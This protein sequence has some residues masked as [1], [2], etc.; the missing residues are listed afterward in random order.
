MN[1]IAGVYKL[2]QKAGHGAFGTVYY[3]KNAISGQKVA[4]KIL[5]TRH[6]KRELSGLIRYRE[7]R[8]VNLLQ[9]HHIDRLPDGR[10]FYTMDLADNRASAGYEADTLAARGRIPVE[11]LV[12]VLQAI[13]NSVEELHRQDLL[14]RDIKPENILFVNGVP[15]LGDIGLTSGVEHTSCAGTP[16]Y[17]P[18]EIL[19]GKRLPD[20][21]ADLYALGRTAYSALTGYAPDKYPDIPGDL[22]PEAAKILAFCRIAGKK[23]ATI[24]K[25]RT[26][27]TEK[28]VFHFS[29][30]HLFTGSFI[31]AV[32][33]GVTIF[34]AVPNKDYPHTVTRSMPIAEKSDDKIQPATSLSDSKLKQTLSEIQ[35]QY[36][37]ISGELAAQARLR[38]QSEHNKSISL[39]KS[40][41][42]FE[43]MLKRQQELQNLEQT[44]KLYH[45]GSILQQIE[46]Y[47]QKLSFSSNTY[48][49]QA[50][51]QLFRERNKLAK[52]LQ[53][54]KNF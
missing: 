30:K 14:H 21:S 23:D 25:L 2:L 8:H 37:D 6:E 32:T 4:L 29:K 45:L 47:T 20:K 1:N 31:L 34:L 12:Y 17:L 49:I 15:V 48:Q 7:C 11:E 51:K 39:L 53:T 10:L 5:D 22:P 13:L 38:Y 3:A 50:L 28:L 40:G 46:F 35:K 18:P 16:Q 19:T 52:E 27:L 42:N 54:E 41:A 26:A 43:A 36:P 24:E 44:D 9:I 33:A